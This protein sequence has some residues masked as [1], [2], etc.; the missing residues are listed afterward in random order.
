MFMRSCYIFCM[1][2]EVSSYYG[3]IL[4]NFESSF[5]IH[6]QSAILFA[7]RKDSFE[8]EINLSFRKINPAI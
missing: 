8:I 5:D 6:V 4:D 7:E 1:L 3:S 2:A